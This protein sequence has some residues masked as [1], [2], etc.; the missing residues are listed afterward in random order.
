LR[1]CTRHLHRPWLGPR[2]LDTRLLN[3][4]LDW[5]RGLRRAEFLAGLLELGTRLLDRASLRHRPGLDCPGLDC[6]RRLDSSRLL[7]VARRLE[8]SGWWGFDRPRL[9]HHSRLHSGTFEI[10][11]LCGLGLR[12]S[13]LFGGPWLLD[14]ARLNGTCLGRRSDL[15]CL[16]GPVASERRAAVSTERAVLS[17]PFVGYAGPFAGCA[18]SFVGSWFRTHRSRPVGA[19]RIVRSLRRRNRRCVQRTLAILHRPG[20][21]ELLLSAARLP[22]ALDGAPGSWRHNPYA[23]VSRRSC[24]SQRRHLGTSKRP[25]TIRPNSRLLTIER[26]RR[27]WRRRT[28]HDRS[29][30]HRGRRTTHIHIGTMTQNTLALWR[31]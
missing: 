31:D 21:T 16:R 23:R 8:L 5:P 11:R 25:S 1:R 26:H 20:R 10:S 19:E 3:G 24:R 2:L 30:H 29:T 4:P 7:H 6:P 28:R 15:L 18:G 22:A 12:S 27:R 14:S 9:R 13:R 17:R